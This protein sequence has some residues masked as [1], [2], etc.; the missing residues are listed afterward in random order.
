MALV[1]L[2]KDYKHKLFLSDCVL[3]V[4]TH[5]T[6]FSQIREVNYIMFDPAR[7]KA[8]VK[9][10]KKRKKVYEMNC[11]FQDTWDT[12]LPW[13]ESIMRDDGRAK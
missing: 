12:K 5:G 13:V 7:A 6:S 2:L 3:M 1:Q 4:F 10:S 9:G 11:R 8:N